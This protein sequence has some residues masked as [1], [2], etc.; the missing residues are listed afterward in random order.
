MGMMICELEL[1]GRAELFGG[2]LFFEHSV[3]SL[4]RDLILVALDDLAARGHG[5]IFSSCLL[6]H[7]PSDFT[8]HGD[9]TRFC[10]DIPA[11]DGPLGAID[12]RVVM[13]KIGGSSA[14]RSIFPLGIILS[15]GHEPATLFPQLGMGNSAG[16]I[17][18][19]QQ[20]DASP[21][22]NAQ[23]FQN[24]SYGSRVAK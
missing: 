4:P 10:R 19:H 16:P 6:R 24:C 12:T 3:V 17:C 5:V 18:L 9:K 22:N 1:P 13:L 11:P 23:P 7:C 2:H 8:D 15:P 20:R 14:L 21:E